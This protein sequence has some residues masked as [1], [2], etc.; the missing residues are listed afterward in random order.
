VSDLPPLPVFHIPDLPAKTITAAQYER[1]MVENLVRLQRAGLVSE[2]LAR[3]ERIP[4]GVR[5]VLDVEPDEG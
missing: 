5:F 4:V 3:P 2:R 1:W